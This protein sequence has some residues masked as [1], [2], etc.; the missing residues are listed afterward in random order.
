MNFEP[1]R[2]ILAA[3]YRDTKGSSAAEFV[4]VLP[5]L[6]L[7]ML[8]IFTF[9]IV[10]QNRMALAQGTSVAARTL[11]LSRGAST[12]YS[13]TRSRFYLSA[14]G[15]VQADLPVTITING[16]ACANDGA[17]AT[18]LGA[19]SGQPAKVSATYPCSMTILGY[20]YFPGCSLYAEATERVE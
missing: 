20:D 9:G 2:T 4:L 18:A 10:L 1:M 15:L 17:C 8:T 12:P 7:L 14:S 6:L 11:A 13:D 5:V 3:F 19:G 16:S